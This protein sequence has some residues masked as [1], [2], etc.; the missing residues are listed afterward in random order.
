MPACLN[1]ILKAYVCLL[2]KLWTLIAFHD[3]SEQ[4]Q[5]IHHEEIIAIA[6]KLPC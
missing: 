3:A 6:E 2:G 4:E 5:Y 1:Q